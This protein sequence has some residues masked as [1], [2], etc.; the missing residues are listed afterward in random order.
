MLFAKINPTAKMGIQEDVF[1]VLISEA[2]YITATAQMYKL[3]Q[4]HTRFEVLFGDF[5]EPIVDPNE[6][7]Q[8]PFKK[9][10]TQVMEFTAEELSSWGADDT[11]VLELIADKL[12]V[13]VVEIVNKEDIY[14]L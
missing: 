1:N 2:P 4:A 5:P 8:P 9:M 6:P 11:V 14:T 7:A 10:L 12:G 3:G 13:D